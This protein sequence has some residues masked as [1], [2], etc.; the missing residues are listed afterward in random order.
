MR[1]RCSNPKEQYRHW[2]DRGIT[3]CERWEKFENFYEDMGPRPSD[4]HSLD[5]IDVDGDYELGNCRWAT[6]S[7]QQRN[8]TDAFKLVIRGKL[9]S[10]ADAAAAHGV[11]ANTA[12]RRIRFYGW[13]P[14]LAVTAPAHSQPPKPY[15]RKKRVRVEAKED[16]R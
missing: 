5:R 16:K 15:K 10:I 4:K 3:V 1:N 9:M 6:Q 8:R 2:R 11:K 13:D 14:E 12:K 7:E